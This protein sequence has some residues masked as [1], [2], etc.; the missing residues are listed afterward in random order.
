MVD[1]A[2]HWESWLET[3]I[4]RTASQR[5]LERSR[6]TEDVARQKGSTYSGMT[7]GQPGG[8]SSLR[9]MVTAC[10]LCILAH[11]WQEQS[12][13]SWLLPQCLRTGIVQYFGNWTFWKTEVPF[14]RS[15]KS[16]KWHVLRNVMKSVYFMAVA[17]G[18]PAEVGFERGRR[19]PQRPDNGQK[20][21]NKRFIQLKTFPGPVARVTSCMCHACLP[22]AIKNTFIWENVLWKNLGIWY[23]HCTVQMGFTVI[24]YWVNL[25]SCV[26]VK[27]A[28]PGS[29]SLIVLTVFVEVKQHCT[30]HGGHMDFESGNWCLIFFVGYV[31]W[32]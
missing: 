19:P 5:L 29:L 28:A 2:F 32:F 31:F 9:L 3:F 24:V 7:L 25:W 8:R 26:K 17:N 15:S 18:Q 12:F 11:F 23:G 30:Y 10:F 6:L 13:F 27:V 4:L 16:E 1:W 14:P 22:S 20:E 21:W